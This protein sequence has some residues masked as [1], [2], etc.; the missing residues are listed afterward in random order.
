MLDWLVGG[1]AALGHV[2][3]AKP[4]EPLCGLFSEVQSTQGSAMV[5]QTLVRKPLC[6]VV[7]AASWVLTMCQLGFWSYFLVLR[8]PCT[9]VRLLWTLRHGMVM[10]L[11]QS[12]PGYWAVESG[13]ETRQSDSRSPAPHYIVGK[14]L[15]SRWPGHT[16][17]LA[18][19]WIL[20]TLS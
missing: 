10:L 4:P 16:I 6:N 14:R 9:P 17:P 8:G 20:S 7:T 1:Q 3:A 18:F 15:G 2:S 11:V 13:F 12:H 5:P 19:S